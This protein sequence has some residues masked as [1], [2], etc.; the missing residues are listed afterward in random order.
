VIP[1]HDGEDSAY[2]LFSFQEDSVFLS[3]K[4]AAVTPNAGRPSLPGSYA[5]GVSERF[6]RRGV[7]LSGNSAGQR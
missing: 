7:I 6:F 4:I 2:D 1:N 3:A 5:E